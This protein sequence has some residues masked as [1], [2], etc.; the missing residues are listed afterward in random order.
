MEKVNLYITENGGDLNQ[1]KI[2]TE[3]F[4]YMNILPISKLSSKTIAIETLSFLKKHWS[5]VWSLKQAH[6]IRQYMAEVVY[7]YLLT[8][9]CNICQYKYLWGK[10]FKDKLDEIYFS[11]VF[12]YGQPYQAYMDKK[13][14]DAYMSQLNFV[15]HYSSI[16]SEHLL[17]ENAM[18]R[19]IY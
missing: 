10:N 16:L 8:T 13:G 4:P 3:H 14:F 19:S 5:K 18:L 7:V 15:T 17:A 11:Y 1:P 12:L 9:I 6:T 2:T